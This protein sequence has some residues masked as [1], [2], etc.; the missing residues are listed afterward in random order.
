MTNGNVEM[1]D[2]MDIFILLICLVLCLPFFTVLHFIR[3]KKVWIIKN[4]PSE[5]KSKLCRQPWEELIIGLL[6]S[7]ACFYFTTCALYGST[8]RYTALAIAEIITLLCAIGAYFRYRHTCDEARETSQSLVKT[9][10]VLQGIH[11]TLQ[12]CACSMLV[13]FLFIFRR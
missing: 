3:W 4:L 8:L 5:L 13:I 1:H 11:S 6:I 10:L 7:S 2:T 12:F 9:L